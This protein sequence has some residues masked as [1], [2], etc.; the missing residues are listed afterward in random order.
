MV[1]IFGKP[2]FDYY[3]KIVSGGLIEKEIT[4]TDFL[5]FWRGH[6]YE[7]E[8]LAYSN[9]EAKFNAAKCAYLSFAKNSV[10]DVSSDGLVSPDLL[11]EIKTRAAVSDEPLDDLRKR[12]SYFIQEQLQM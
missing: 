4:K 5:N 8:A 11:I 12:S 9:K 2:K 10:F 7:S 6:Q 1:G 3:L